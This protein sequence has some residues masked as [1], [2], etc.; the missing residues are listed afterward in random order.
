M[1]GSHRATWSDD[2][3]KVLVCAYKFGGLTLEQMTKAV[4]H[5]AKTFFNACST[6]KT[7]RTPESLVFRLI[8]VRLSRRWQGWVARALVLLHG[9]FLRSS[10][11]VVRP[12]RERTR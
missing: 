10:W 11:F 5:D 3:F 1:S 9:Q 2:G 6:G 7:G 8:L 12:N 4:V